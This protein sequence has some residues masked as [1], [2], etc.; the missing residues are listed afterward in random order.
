MPEGND[1]I[2]SPRFSHAGAFW[3]DPLAMTVKEKKQSV[4]IPAIRGQAI[5]FPFIPLLPQ[6]RPAPPRYT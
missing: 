4:S 1:G 2:A 5:S 3:Q 6:A